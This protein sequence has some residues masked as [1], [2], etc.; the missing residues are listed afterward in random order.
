MTLQEA[1]DLIRP[2][3]VPPS[4]TW[5]DIGAGTGLFTEALM[6]ILTEG[7]VI[8]LDKNTHVLYQSETLLFDSTQLKKLKSNIELE[9]IEADF[10]KP[11]KLPLLDGILMANSL[12]YAHDHVTV[13]KNVLVSLKPAGTFLLIEYDTDKPNPPWIPNPVPFKKFNELCNIL[14]LEKPIVIGNRES[15]YND[16]NMYVA[17]TG[18]KK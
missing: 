14:N 1:I 12:H 3:V 7:K 11:M 5:A 13:L 17:A 15:I 6:S 16:G 2:A 18:P 10:H 8:A 4:G 9:I